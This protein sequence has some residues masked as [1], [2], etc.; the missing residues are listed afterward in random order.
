MPSDIP[1]R[2][3]RPRTFFA[4]LGA[5]LILTIGWAL[6]TPL[7]GVPDEPSHTIRAAAVVRGEIVGDLPP[8]DGKFHYPT[9]DVPDYIQETV[10]LP[11]FGGDV[12]K[13]AECQPDIGDSNRLVEF[14][15]SAASNNPV[16]YAIVGLP[17]LVM[18]GE[19]ALYGMRTVSALVFSLMLTI[20]V[21]ALHAQSRT[22]WPVLG[23]VVAATPGVIFLGSAINPNGVEVA[24]AG[25]LFAVIALILRRD[26]SRSQLWLYAVAVIAS[27][28]A[29]TSGRTLAMLWVVVIAL[30]CVVMVPPR[31]LLAVLRLPQI[32]VAL[33]GMAV[34]ALWVVIWMTQISIAAVD[35]SGAVAARAPGIKQV[36]IIMVEGTFDS[37]TAWIGQFGWLDYNAPPG[38]QM[39]WRV[40]I[41]VILFGA[42]VL[43]KGRYRAAA[44]VGILAAVL[45]PAFVQ[46]SLYNP[47]GWLWQGR[48]GIA[49]YTV[50]LLIGALALD[51]TLESRISPAQ[52]R[53]VRAGLALLGIA[54]I[55][56]LVFVLR[57]YV[58]ASQDWFAMFTNPLWHPPLTW[59]G[60]SAVFTI[61]VVGGFVLLMRWVTTE[62]RLSNEA[63]AGGHVDPAA[64][65]GTRTP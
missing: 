13:S 14:S 40:A 32:W 5:F 8:D 42:V 54:H 55:T 61:G 63:E 25:A 44:I 64:P 30:V 62:R 10:H 21:V 37:W 29:L 22:I 33:A 7:M 20:M 53:L 39:I 52:N 2:S 17:T 57:R 51:N 9:I 12:G 3:V 34:T 49:L 6:A 18:T 45:V 28:V 36:L 56:T 26:L 11:C 48:Y 27:T 65:H 58:V 15:S 4:I 19:A 43:A 1:A 24:G 59:V 38:V 41:V 46:G 16:Y 35:P 23:G 50:M 47:V 60:V 31:R